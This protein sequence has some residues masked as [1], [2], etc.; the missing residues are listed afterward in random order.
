MIVDGTKSVTKTRKMPAPWT[1]EVIPGGH[2]VDDA[3]GKALAYCYG[4]PPSTLPAAGEASLSLDEAR[5][6]ASNIGKLAEL[7]KG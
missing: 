5:R 3:E 2:R 7:L 6:V 1:V 4:L